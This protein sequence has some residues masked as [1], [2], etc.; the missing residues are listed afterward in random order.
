M[1][2]K[3]AAAIRHVGFEDLGSFA[4]PIERAGYKIQYYDIG[5]HD[6]STIDA[7]GTDL[8][9]VLGGPI[10]VYETDAYPFL[11]DEIAILERRLNADRPT[12]GICLGAQLIAR[13]LGSS[14]YPGARKEIGWAPVTLTEIG[15]MSLLA[16]LDETPVLHWHGD[17]FDLPEGCELLGSTEVCQNQA[18]SRGPN[19]LG[20]QF[21][22]EA[23]VQGFERW[24]VGHAC[25][26]SVSGLD[27]RGLRARAEACA[28]SLEK[29]ATAMMGE[30]LRRLS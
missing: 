21:H 27:P 4:A 25:E 16:H 15:R 23:R 3:I 18:F 5:E 26:L 13:A 10:G 1:T 7:I 11:M 29:R 9:I 12:L 24:L 17:T 28:S 6:P 8:F 19:V 20:L 30:W 2:L 14:V 22:A